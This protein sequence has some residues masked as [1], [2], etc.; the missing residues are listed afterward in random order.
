MFPKGAVR[1]WK[2]L[3]K[4]NGGKIGDKGGGLLVRRKLSPGFHLTDTAA[5]CTSYLIKKTE[6]Y[7]QERKTLSLF[8]VSSYLYLKFSDS[9]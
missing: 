2:K 6:E 1:I 5:V 8:T 3:Y 7:T 9:K 4:G